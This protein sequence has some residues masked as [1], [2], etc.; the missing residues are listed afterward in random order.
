MDW[1]PETGWSKFTYEKV[2][3]EGVQES[4]VW[5]AQPS[6]LRH[7]GWWERDR[8]VRVFGLTDRDWMRWERGTLVTEDEEVSDNEY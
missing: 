6:L 2:T 8:T 3:P 4:I 7:Q 1:N 5:R